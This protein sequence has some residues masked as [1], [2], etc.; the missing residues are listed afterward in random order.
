MHHGSH[1]PAALHKD[2]LPVKTF[3]TSPIQSTHSR[4]GEPSLGLGP[5]HMGR[6]SAFSR[7]CSHIKASNTEKQFGQSHR[8]SFSEPQP[9]A[10][11][12][13]RASMGLHVQA[14]NSRAK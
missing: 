13:N 8:A 2:Q 5:L 4:A 11:H 10:G 6:L 3:H 1:P 12:S 14:P 9:P 7:K